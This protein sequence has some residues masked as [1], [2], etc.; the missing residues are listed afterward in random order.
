[1]EHKVKNLENK[2]D[3]FLDIASDN[4]KIIKKSMS[5]INFATKNFDKAPAIELL[6]GKKLNKF[7]EYNEKPKRRI[8]EVIIHYNEK[9]ELDQF[10]GNLIIN[11][12]KKDDPCEQSMWSSDTARLTFIIKQSIN[13]TN[14]SK[15]IT[16]KK[17]L[18]LSKLIIK[19]LT[20]KVKEILK[21]YVT[22]CNDFI[23]GRKEL[24]EDAEIDIKYKLKQMEKANYVIMF[25]NL[26][27]INNDILKYITPY[28][29]LD[30]SKVK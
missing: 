27:K 5:T 10:L 8:E 23:L 12:Y 6:G 24:N 11:T 20:N 17:G 26:N 14:E 2:C 16:D 13:E 9:K 28:F 29:N 25:I 4:T 1:M 3:K 19:P 15:W 22:E 21:E 7:I 30:T 18:N